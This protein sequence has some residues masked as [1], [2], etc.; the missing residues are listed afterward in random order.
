MTVSHGKDVS[1]KHRAVEGRLEEQNEIERVNGSGDARGVGVGGGAS[2]SSHLSSQ[3]GRQ[4]YPSATSIETPTPF[5]AVA[6]TGTL[7]P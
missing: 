7:R 1:I 5:A 6:H 4:K 2:L 3:R